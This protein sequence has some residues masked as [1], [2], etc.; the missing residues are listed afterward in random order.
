[1]K[2]V[3]WWT[4]LPTIRFEEGRAEEI[5]FP[6]ATFDRVTAVVAFHHIEDQGRAIQEM[7]RVLR[8]SGR[9]VLFE[10]PPS[11][12]PGPIYQWI[13]GYGTGATWRS[14]VR[15]SSP[16]KCVPADSRRCQTARV[17]W[18]ISCSQRNDLPALG[19]G[20]AR[21]ASLSPSSAP[22]RTKATS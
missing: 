13:A 17:L 4:L 8:D 22:S 1:M 21:P 7:R 14:T 9:L 16:R 5:P 2:D 12:A 20:A 18:D 6:D 10:M 15:I 11:R 19:S 3:L